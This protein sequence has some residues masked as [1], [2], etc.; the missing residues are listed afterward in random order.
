MRE[1]KCK[2]YVKSIRKNSRRIQ[3]QMKI[4]IQI[5]QHLGKSGDG[6]K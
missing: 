4:R 3:N 1:Y 5:L 2:I 6:F